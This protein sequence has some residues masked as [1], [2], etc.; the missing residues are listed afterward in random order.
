LAYDRNVHTAEALMQ[1][2]YR[3][4]PAAEFLASCA[5]DTSYARSLENTI[6]TIPS[7]EL[8]R[9]RGGAHCMSCPLIRD[10]FVQT[11]K[12]K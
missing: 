3:I 7:A 11:L 1:H 10:G 4:L 2:G 5:D 12:T 9:A 8:S 6:V